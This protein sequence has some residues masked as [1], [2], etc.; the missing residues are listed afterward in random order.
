M[1]WFADPTVWVGLVTLVVLEIVLGVDNLIFLAILSEKLPPRQRQ[2]ARVIGLS[3]AGI[4]AMRGQ[5]LD[6]RYPE[7][8][9]FQEPKKVDPP[10]RELK[11]QGEPEV[12]E[13]PQA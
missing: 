1:D 2:R 3:L 6:Q 13:P 5:Q 9:D 4:V 12:D 10:L 8:D 7:S 11:I